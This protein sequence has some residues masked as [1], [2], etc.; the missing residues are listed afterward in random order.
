MRRQGLARFLV[1]QLLHYVQEQYFKSAEVQVPEGNA[2]ALGLF[3][4]LGFEQV[5]AGRSFAKDEPVPSAT[6]PSS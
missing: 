4:G 2:A 5:D 6:A 3:Q 1:N